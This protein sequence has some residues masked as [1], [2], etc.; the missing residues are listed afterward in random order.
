[1]MARQSREQ[2][3]SVRSAGGFALDAQAPGYLDDPYPVYHALRAESP[4]W[5]SPSG[6]WYLSGYDDV[7][8]LLNDQRFQR[9]S[10][11][12]TVPI[13]GDSRPATSIDRMLSRWMVFTD[14]PAHTRL[15][16][17]FGKAFTP[18]RIA[19]LRDEVKGIADALLD[20]A[21]AKSSF[22]VIADFA[23]PLPVMVVSRILGVP[24]ADYGRLMDWS[25]QL[26]GAL[27]S[28]EASELATGI[29]ASEAMLAYMAEL[30]TE[31]RRAPREDFLSVLAADGDDDAPGADELLANCVFLL[32]AGHE[33]T[34]NLIGNGTLA[35]MRHPGELARLMAD[36]SLAESG[37]DEFLRYESPIQ[38]VGRW[39]REPV[40]FGDR[41][42][43]AGHY[44]VGLLGAA[45]R[46]PQRFADPDRLDVSRGAGHGVAFGRGIHHCLGYRL[47]KLEGE[48][49]F[50]AL[51]QRVS[52]L[53]PAFARPQWQANSSIRGLECL[54]VTVRW[55]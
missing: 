28:G 2:A 49:A 22:D 32:W 7:L 29:A 5:L 54:P 40:D 44:V 37:V 48:V 17:L 10:P 55:R 53:E 52:A 12:G 18:R 19:V 9:Q 23:Y 21:L 3:E 27:D 16:R 1:M 11:G 30:I 43:P 45:N 46:D 34:K 50:T 13:S 51:L 8:T 25:A 41:Q 35:L 31:R 42:I 4:L 15:R 38:K 47:A 26:T 33:T 20:E 24:A 36:P 14:P 6:A 39:T